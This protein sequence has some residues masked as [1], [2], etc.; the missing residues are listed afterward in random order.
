M[1]EAENVDDAM[2]ILQ[3]VKPDLLL[4]DIGMPAQDGYQL[5]ERVRQLPDDISQIPAIA[6]TAYAR[7]EERARAVEAGFQLHLS[8]PTNKSAVISAIAS[9]VTFDSEQTV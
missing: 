8:K 1:S 7:E 6:L 2:R 4:S 9:L 5:I 3:S